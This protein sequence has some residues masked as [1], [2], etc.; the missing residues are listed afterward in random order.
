V[1]TLE[2][3]IGTFNKIQLV[4]VSQIIFLQNNSFTE[5]F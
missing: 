2:I 4:A 3:R 1:Y 5:F